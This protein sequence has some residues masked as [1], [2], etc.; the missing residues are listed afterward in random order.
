M[1]RAALAYAG[2]WV[3]GAIVWFVERRDAE[4]R[5]H[6]VQ[7]TLAFGAGFLLWLLLW[8][9][10]F[11]VLTFSATG[12]FVLQ[13][14]AQGVLLAVL[15]TWAYC[16]WRVWSGGTVRLPLVA[17]RADRLAARTPPPA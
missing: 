3:T 12:F 10:S 13:R 5:F 1:P 2:W 7:S 4:L 9:C 17:E 11:L 14:L 8:T 16:L 6:A 15:V